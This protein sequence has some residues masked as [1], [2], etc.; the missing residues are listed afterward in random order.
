MRQSVQ[1]DI[2]IQNQNG[3]LVI[4]QRSDRHSFILRHWKRRFSVGT[5]PLHISYGLDVCAKQCLTNFFKMWFLCLRFSSFVVVVVVFR[6]NNNKKIHEKAF[7]RASIFR[8]FAVLQAD[9]FLMLI[10]ILVFQK[11]V[12]VYSERYNTAQSSGLSLAWWDLISTTFGG[13]AAYPLYTWPPLRDMSYNKF[14]V[15][16]FSKRLFLNVYRPYC[17]K[18]SKIYFWI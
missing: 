12:F 11:A 5:I 2:W 3:S 15:H 9:I 13:H 1:D 4:H 17:V 8:S 16:L 18:K 6:E 7:Q 10:Y 14:S